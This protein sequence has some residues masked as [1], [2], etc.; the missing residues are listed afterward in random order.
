MC[1]LIEKVL[2][3][4]TNTRQALDGF[5]SAKY[6][7]GAGRVRGARLPAGTA[8][9][10]AAGLSNIL[11]A[12]WLLTAGRSRRQETTEDFSVVRLRTDNICRSSLAPIRSSASIP[13]ARG[14]RRV[15]D[16]LRLPANRESEDPRRAGAADHQ[17]GQRHGGYIRGA[18]ARS[19]DQGRATSHKARRRS[20]TDYPADAPVISKAI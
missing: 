19:T 14:Q 5:R 13:R 7:W 20:A 16:R 10:R 18:G 2:S 8:C 1:C 4:P 12:P 3:T 9:R 6:Q 15:C 11:R 17:E